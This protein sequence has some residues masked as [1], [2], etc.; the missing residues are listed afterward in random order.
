MKFDSNRIYNIVYVR[1]Y[2]WIVKQLENL[3][4]QLW[5]NDFR[6]E[7]TIIQMVNNSQ[8]LVF[9]QTGCKAEHGQ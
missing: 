4:V 8:R 9:S 3:D 6:Y 1:R 5:N 2:H 7:I